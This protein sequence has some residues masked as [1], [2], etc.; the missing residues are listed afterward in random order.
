MLI[1]PLMGPI[2]SIGLALS[3][4]DWGLMRRSLRNLLTLIIISIGISTVYF[5]L[6]PITN[7]G[8]ELLSRI[9]PTILMFSFAIFGGAAGFIGISRARHNNIIPGVAI[10]TAIMPPSLYCRLRSWNLTNPPSFLV[11]STSS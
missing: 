5:A 4:N 1:S 8:S 10:A 3:I 7:A 2:V 9:Q 6:S 11:P